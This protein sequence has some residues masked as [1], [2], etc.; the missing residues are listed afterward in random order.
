MNAAGIDVSKGKSMVSV[1]RPLGEVVAKP[2]EVRHTASELRGLADY[3]KSL[4]GETRVILEHTGRYYGPVVE[5]LHGSGVYVSA[6]NP[7]RIKDYGNNSLRH[8][9]TDK[10]RREED[11]QV[12]S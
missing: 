9:K 5:I 1:L 3:L 11:C 12:W 8:V 7:K 6:V 10:G 4:K 2:F